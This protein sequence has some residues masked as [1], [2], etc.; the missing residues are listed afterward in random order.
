[1]GEEAA[2]KKHIPSPART[3]GQ[4]G[5]WRPSS[6][7]R[8]R[9]SKRDPTPARTAGQ[10][11]QWHRGSATGRAADQPQK[12]LVADGRL[13][14]DLTRARLAEGRLDPEGSTRKKRRDWGTSRASLTTHT[15]IDLLWGPT[16]T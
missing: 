10:A 4:A 2:N 16:P 3:A 13:D 15:L 1:V 6:A 14:D 7:T 11:G 5:Q 9:N 12:P 8:R